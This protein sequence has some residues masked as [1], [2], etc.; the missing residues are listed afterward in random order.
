MAE[1]LTGKLFPSILRDPG[2]CSIFPWSTVCPFSGI[3]YTK[4]GVYVAHESINAQISVPEFNWDKFLSLLNDIIQLHWSG[5]ENR[6]WRWWENLFHQIDC[7]YLK[8]NCS[9]WFEW[10]RFRC[11]EW[12]LTSMLNNSMKPFQTREQVL[13]DLRNHYESEVGHFKGAILPQSDTFRQELP[14]VLDMLQDKK[15][16]KIVFIVPVVCVAKNKRVF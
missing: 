13:V 2:W 14:M 12:G 6:G 10:W 16:N 3:E 8:E 9:G 11:D 5:F 4:L 15:N 7:S 1:I